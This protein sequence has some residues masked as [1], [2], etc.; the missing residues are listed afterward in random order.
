MK[1]YLARI[2]V[3]N[4]KID[5]NWLLVNFASVFS[6]E[7]CIKHPEL[8]LT[9][10]QQKIGILNGYTICEFREIEPELLTTDDINDEY[11]NS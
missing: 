9:A 6:T 5:N 8:I 11:W 10:S 7:V 1:T 3:L 2:L 4:E